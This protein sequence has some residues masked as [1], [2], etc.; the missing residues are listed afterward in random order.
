MRVLPGTRGTEEFPRVD[1]AGIWPNTI[2]CRPPWGLP[3]M[4]PGENNYSPICMLVQN[5]KKTDCLHTISIKSLEF[6]KNHGY[7]MNTKDFYDYVLFFW[8][9]N[10]V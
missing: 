8:I 10:C 1:E 6:K 4:L 5:L 9:E 3:G 2:P 7:Q